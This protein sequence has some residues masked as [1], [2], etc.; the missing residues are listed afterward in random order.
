MC[1]TIHEEIKET[2][3]KKVN[4]V[5]EKDK[6]H[7]HVISKLTEPWWQNRD[8]HIHLI[9]LYL[10]SSCCIYK[11]IQKSMVF[12]YLSHMHA[13]ILHHSLIL[14]NTLVMGLKSGI[15][16]KKISLQRLLLFPLLLFTHISFFIFAHKIR[17]ARLFEP[18]SFLLLLPL[19][20]CPV[21]CDQWIFS[22]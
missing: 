10:K 2:N 4:K 7:I 15:Y 20:F 18:L 21:R 14:K 19:D 11:I 16:S 13:S 1:C 17:Q 3:Y 9:H 6:S 12:E 22:F 8:N 5:V